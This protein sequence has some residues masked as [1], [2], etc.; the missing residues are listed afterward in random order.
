MKTPRAPTRVTAL[1]SGLLL[2]I[3][4]PVQEFAGKAL[5]LSPETQNLMFIATLVF[6][7]LGP[8]LLFVIGVQYLAFG[9]K[10]LA[11]TPYWSSLAQAGV[12]SLFWLL[13]CGL[14]FALLAIVHL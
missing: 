5:G 1:A 13:G 6:A 9:W 8:V 14:G 11:T 12:R 7:F 10:D 2:G 4:L 3:V